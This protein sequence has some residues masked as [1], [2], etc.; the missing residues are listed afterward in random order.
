[1]LQQTR[2]KWMTSIIDIYN[3]NNN[4]A[5]NLSSSKT[6]NNCEAEKGLAT[7]SGHFNTNQNVASSPYYWQ[8]SFSAPVTIE[9]Y[10]IKGQ[11]GWSGWPTSWEISYSLDGSSFTTKQIDTTSDLRSASKFTINPPISCKHFKITG[12]TTNTAIGLWFYKFDCFGSAQVLFPRRT[13]IQCTCNIAR[14]KYQLVSRVL[15]MTMISRVIS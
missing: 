10:I 3:A 9:S 4:L 13:K 12:L 1:M 15:I 14:V 7:D 5:Y 8:I 6:Y 2:T 11:S